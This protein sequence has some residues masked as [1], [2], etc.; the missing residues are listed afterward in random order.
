MY[1]K[2]WQRGRGELLCSGILV[3][4]IFPFRK[5]SPQDT[6]GK[7]AAC[8]AHLAAAEGELAARQTKYE[9][10]ILRSAGDVDVKTETGEAKRMHGFVLDQRAVAE[11]A[12]DAVVAAERLHAEAQAREQQAADAKLWDHVETLAAARTG[13]ADAVER[14]ASA[15]AEAIA[16]F[17]G[18]NNAVAA[19]LPRGV[20]G[21]IDFSVSLVRWQNQITCEL[22]RAGITGQVPY[23]KPES[24]T[25]N[26]RGMES[27]VRKHRPAT[28]EV[29]P[30]A[31]AA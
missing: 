28:A 3:P 15:L 31:E 10:A 20:L 12:R 26:A 29:E 14:A 4:T 24:I 7:L 11:R 19:A 13:A 5:S 21:H 9:H 16:A 25:A 6:A 27:I 23:P 1:N 30:T 17:S 2:S 22:R 18:A 8:R